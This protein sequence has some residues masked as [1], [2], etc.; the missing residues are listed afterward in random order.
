[1]QRLIRLA[2]AA[3]PDVP[4]VIE[5]GIKDFEVVVATVSSRPPEPRRR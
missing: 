1:M 3:L 4:T 2:A 5:S